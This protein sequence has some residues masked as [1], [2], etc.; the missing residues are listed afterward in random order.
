[1]MPN[2]VRLF[3][4]T[5][6]TNLEAICR[7]DALVSK[8]R[9]GHHGINYQ[10]IAHAGAQGARSQ[11]AVVDPPGGVL[12]D[13]V[14]FYF[15]PRSPMLSAILNGRVDGCQLTQQDI[16]YFETT[17]DKVVTA[18]LEFAFYDRNAT[19]SYSNSYTDLS[20]L[21]SVIAWDLLTEPP[22]SDGYCM[23]FLDRVE[24][25][26]YVDRMEK[27]QAE[28]IIKDQ[29]PLNCFTRI[30]VIDDCMKNEVSRILLAHALKLKVDIM[31]DWYFLGQKS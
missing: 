26:K 13:Y 29:I 7:Q 5:A 9:V 15:A 3:H 28:F 14:P 23:Y 18:N 25:P 8:N 21:S 6:L 2:P 22:Q 11:R 20:L 24:N 31:T 27:R 19:R 1:M 10:N 17:V 4:I 16:I 12:H 30:G